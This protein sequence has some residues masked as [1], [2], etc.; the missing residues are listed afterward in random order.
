MKKKAMHSIPRTTLGLTASARKGKG[1]KDHLAVLT[2]KK[3]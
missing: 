1:S 3:W 2:E